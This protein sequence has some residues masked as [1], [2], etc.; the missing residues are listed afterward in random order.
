MQ[1]TTSFGGF[2]AATLATASMV[3]AFPTIPP[4][5][6][7]P[8]SG[9][10][11]MKQVRNNKYNGKS[12]HGTIALEKAYLKFGV[13]IPDDVSSAVSRVRNEVLAD[14]AALGLYKRSN[15]TGSAVTTPQEYDVEYL[16]PVQIGTPPQTLMLDFDTGSSDLW[17]YS[18][19]TPS[20]DV[21][22]QTVYDPDA[23]DTSM[24]LA[25]HTWSIS[26]GDGSSSK[27]DVYNDNVTIGGMS[28][29]PMA[30]EAAN[31]VSAEFTSDT[32]IDGLLG[33]AFSK[34]NTVT[35]TKQ[36]T[37][38]EAAK[39]QLASYLFTVDLK[40]GEPGTY[41]FGYIDD[42]AYTGDISYTPVDTSNGW[43]KFSTTG[44]QVGDQEYQTEPISGIADTGT[45]LMLLPTD[46]TVAYY[47]SVPDAKYDQTQG[48]YVFPCDA[49][50]PD[51][52]F[53]VGENT[54]VVPGSFINYSPVDKTNSSCYGG[55][56]G[57]S[58]IGFAIFGDVALKAAFVVFDGENEQLGFATKDL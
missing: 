9:I 51:F 41:N 25:N 8:I 5:V 58:S 7:V 1:Y 56:Q 46:V 28:V 19:N 16:T 43:W 18:S 57:D 37:F 48:G 39:D 23:S 55:I 52:S 20:S 44:Y 34:L 30:V 29:Y 10:S 42:K 32:D 49:D 50:L 27:G 12:K 35:P 4:R 47:Q 33:L 36:K 53:G 2:L 22:G 21:K 15:G 24:K 13:T 40:A 26:Y 17:V 45:T 14:L 11:S 6:P 31:D 3:S 38:F 54:I